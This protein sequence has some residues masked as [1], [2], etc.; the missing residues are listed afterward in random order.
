MT[1]IQKSPL[2]NSECLCVL[3][4]SGSASQVKFHFII[5][6]VQKNVI[7]FCLNTN[8]RY[9]KKPTVKVLEF[10]SKLVPF[11]WFFFKLTNHEYHLGL[12]EI[13]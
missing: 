13:K 12:D 11:E 10:K 5:F 1:V 3:S 9:S 8:L 6:A 7:S 2:G 4:F